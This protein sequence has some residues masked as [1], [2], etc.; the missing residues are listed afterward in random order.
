[1]LA[2][3]PPDAPPEGM[4]DELPPLEPPELPPLGM[5]ELEP[6]PELPDDPPDEPPEGGLGI[7]GDGMLLEEED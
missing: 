5:L 1:M 4:L 2:P 3:P 7:V 6:P